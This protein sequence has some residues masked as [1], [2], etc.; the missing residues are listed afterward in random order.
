MANKGTPPPRN[1]SGRDRA[2]ARD[3][4]KRRADA[5]RRTRWLWIGLGIAVATAALIAVLASSGSKTTTTASGVEQTRD[6]QISGTALPPF[7]E[8]AD[9]AVGQPIPEV[10]GSS[11]DGSALAIT[12]DGKAKVLVF[13]AHWCPHCQKEV[14]L[15]SAYLPTHP[16]PSNVSLLTVSTSVSADRLNYPPSAW[17]ADEHWPAPVIADSDQGA[18]A[19]A[20]GLVSLPY[21]VAV[22]ANGNVVARTSGE[23]TTDQFDALVQQ[24]A[25][26]T[27]ASS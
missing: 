10:R 4:A 9:A 8:G 7:A 24:A 23:I 12:R 18:A 20:F 22:D 17:L 15:L 3:N 26:G 13:V 27:K 5:R 19:N 16:M 2:H 25:S 11:F 6:V 14:P 1:A 21:F